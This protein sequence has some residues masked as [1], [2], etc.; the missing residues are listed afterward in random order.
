[1]P[2][3][4]FGDRFIPTLGL[5]LQNSA[6]DRLQYA[7]E[8]C[9]NFQFT[10]GHYGKY[11]D[12]KLSVCGIGFAMRASGSTDEE[13]MA[14]SGNI[15]CALKTIFNYKSPSRVMKE[16]GFDDKTRRKFR[17]CVHE[18]CA[19][20]GSLQL[21]LEHVNECHKTPIPLIG[22]YVIPALRDQDKLY[23]PTL[24]DQLII[25]KRDFLSLFKKD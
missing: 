5:D 19:F 11:E 22:K 10:D 6:W 7:Y 14:V 8:S 4:E 17:T 23:K 9:D 1:M 21:V 25:M 16:Y 18:N 3:P 20:R 2:N 24:A 12:G 15:K 13:L